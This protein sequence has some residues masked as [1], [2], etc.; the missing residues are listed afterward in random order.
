[1]TDRNYFALQALPTYYSTSA[2][3][4]ARSKSNGG[5]QNS[6]LVGA[7]AL[8]GT[9]TFAGAATGSIWAAGE[10]S[11]AIAAYASVG[12]ET[13]I[14]GSAAAIS[15]IGALG[16]TGAML[17]AGAGVVLTVP[18]GAGYYIGTKISPG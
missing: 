13:F 5:E 15:D 9:T 6:F 4:I 2:S 17:G 7:G 3:P 14:I 12:G 8:V 18:L 16:L 1:L 10:A 11:G